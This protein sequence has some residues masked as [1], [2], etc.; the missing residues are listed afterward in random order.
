MAAAATSVLL[1]CSR[2]ASRWRGLMA[3][4]GIAIA[5]WRVLPQVFGPLCTP[6][7]AVDH[8]AP[9]ARRR[10]RR[11][12]CWSTAPATWP[13]ATR[14]SRWRSRP[15]RPPDR[16]VL[17]RRARTPTPTTTWPSN[18]NCS[19]RWCEGV[20]V[21]RL[22]RPA[23]I[24]ALTVSMMAGMREALE[25]WRRRRRRR[26]R[27]PARRGF[28]WAMRRCADVRALRDRRP[29]GPRLRGVL[30]PGVRPRSGHQGVPQTVRSAPARHHHGRWA[31]DLRARIAPA[32]L[33][34]RG[35]RDAG[36]HHRL[37]PRCRDQLVPGARP[38][39]DR[40]ARRAD[41]DNGRC[42]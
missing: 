17:W 22:N 30:R 27:A 5:S 16:A 4:L 42:P 13:G 8:P 24:N 20:G 10:H 37:H 41:R 2:A 35:L 11:L 18:P 23:A 12:G 40:H 21:L 34:G 9:P 29:R 38:G 25:A 28:P 6:V 36:D 1:V 15:S 3:R 14:P 7:P 26:Q 31:R 33:G 32:R 19:P 39:V